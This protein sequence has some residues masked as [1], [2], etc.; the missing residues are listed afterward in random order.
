M[1]KRLVARISAAFAGTGC[2][3]VG[4]VVEGSPWVGEKNRSR[5]ENKELP[6]GAL[7]WGPKIKYAGSKG[8]SSVDFRRL[9]FLGTLKPPCMLVELK[10]SRCG[11][12]ELPES[13]G[14]LVNLQKFDCFTNKLTGEF[15][16]TFLALPKTQYAVSHD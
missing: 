9:E 5:R 8:S 12:T 14:K 3:E 15:P 6:K 4:E 7:P 1:E 11:L 13:I 16:R 2:M 10:L